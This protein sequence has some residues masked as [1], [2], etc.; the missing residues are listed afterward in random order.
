M[1]NKCDRF[2]LAFGSQRMETPPWPVLW[3]RKVALLDAKTAG[4]RPAAPDTVLPAERM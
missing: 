3:P 2:K 4:H 1:V